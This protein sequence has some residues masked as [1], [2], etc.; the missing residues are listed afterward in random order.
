[1]HKP[2]Y[3]NRN[4]LLLWQGNLFSKLGDI[5]YSIAIGIWVF[6]K[7]GST[8][9]MGLMSSISLFIAGFFSP[10]CGAIADRKNRRNIIVITDAL[11]GIA[12]I[13]LGI[14]AIN[15]KME[16]WMVLAVAALAGFCNVFFSPAAATVVSLILKPQDLLA[17]QCFV[18]GSN[19]LVQMIAK[20][21]SGGL[22]VMFG[23]PTM[24][25]IN[26]ISFL[27]SA[28]SEIFIQVP[29][30][31]IEKKKLNAGMIVQDMK[32]AFIYV[33][34]RKGLLPLMSAAFTLNL[35]GSG[36]G[37]ILYPFLLEK[38]FT[39]T[40]YG[41]FLSIESAAAFAAVSLLS[42]VKLKHKK[43]II[44]CTC[45]V[46]TT[47]LNIAMIIAKGFLTVNIINLLAVFFNV[48]F[49]SM[50]NASLILSIEEQKRGK[51]LGM[52]IS[53]SSLGQAASSL[54]YGCVAGILGSVNGSLFITALTV[55]PTVWF[56]FNRSIISLLDEDPEKTIAK[57]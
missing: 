21:V 52:V 53:F 24:I 49:N 27:I 42:F 39:V 15:G 1:M 20:A 7:T 14:L 48:V 35:L 41:W 54:L 26:G 19:S 30:S 25:L 32:E 31:S 10:L 50:L 8:A 16:V 51:V 29:K 5:L 46:L 3:F 33:A 6:D 34:N 43:S 55:I 18:E 38:G 4:F 40:E 37:S 23:V 44:M 22:V 57:A 12:M 56:V 36:L 28:F 17:G 45:M 9:L 11:R 47:I 2:Q 13:I